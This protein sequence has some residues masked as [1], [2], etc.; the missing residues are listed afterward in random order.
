[1]P[2]SR[3][4]TP[5]ASTIAK[6]FHAAQAAHPDRE[7]G[8]ERLGEFLKIA[9]RHVEVLGQVWHCFAGSARDEPA[10]QH[11]PL[12]PSKLENTQGDLSDGE[13]L[14]QRLPRRP[15]LLDC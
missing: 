12:Q 6:A 3:H 10:R 4:Q 11:V 14:R 2:N 13:K 9:A 5:E 1:V 7:Q 15:H 8:C